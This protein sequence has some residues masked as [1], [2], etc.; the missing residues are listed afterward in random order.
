MK[1]FDAT[2][3]I[4]E[5]DRAILQYRKLQAEQAAKDMIDFWELEKKHPH[6]LAYIS[7]GLLGLAV[8][9][10]ITFNR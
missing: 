4:T 3:D 6:V 1:V 2:R 7:M 5:K 10:F 9:L 8:L